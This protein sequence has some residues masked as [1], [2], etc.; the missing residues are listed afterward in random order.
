MFIKKAREFTGLWVFHKWKGYLTSS[1]CRISL[2]DKKSN[3]NVQ[4]C[5]TKLPILLKT[6]HYPIGILCIPVLHQLIRQILFHEFHLHQFGDY[7]FH[8]YYLC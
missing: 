1:Y 8:S 3:Y 5:F 4:V 7:F 6:N 2:D